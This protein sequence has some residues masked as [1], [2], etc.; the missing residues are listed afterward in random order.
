MNSR[1]DKSPHTLVGLLE[2]GLE[3]EVLGGHCGGIRWVDALYFQP[4]V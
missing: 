1:I 3:R 4:G 2:L